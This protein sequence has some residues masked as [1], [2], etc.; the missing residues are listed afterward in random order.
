MSISTRVRILCG[1]SILFLV[2]FASAAAQ[3]VSPDVYAH[4]NWRLIGPF[5]GGRVLAVA[6]V[7]TQPH[8]YY[9]G[10]ANGGVWKTTNSGLS[11]DPIFND[12]PVSSIGAIAVVPFDPNVVYVGTG[13]ADPRSD[14]TFGDGVYKSTD[15]GKTWANIG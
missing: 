3:T 12:K 9:F 13:E 11:W 4:L 15:A 1:L 5:D 7:P 6:G 14:A 8:T 2:S 10:S